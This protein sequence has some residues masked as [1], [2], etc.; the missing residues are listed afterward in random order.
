MSADALRRLANATPQIDRDA[1]GRITQI[2]LGDFMLEKMNGREWFLCV[3]GETF[4]VTT[5]HRGVID[6][7]HK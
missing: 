7:E 5:K 1:D 2:A 4:W 6:V 3:G